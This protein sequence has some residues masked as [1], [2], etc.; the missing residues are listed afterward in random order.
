MYAAEDT[1]LY[2]T[3]E[4]S[5]TTP[6]CYESVRFVIFK[7]PV[8]VSERQV[9]LYN[10]KTIPLNG[11]MQTASFYYST[12]TNRTQCMKQ[13]DIVSCNLYFIVVLY[14]AFWQSV[15]YVVQQVGW[16]LLAAETANGG[17]HV[18]LA[19]VFGSWLY[20]YFCSLNIRRHHYVPPC[21]GITQ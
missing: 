7:N 13:I 9:R 19:Y 5:L 4:G 16:T 15:R 21:H 1:K 3:Y 2:W 6:P 8:E 14:V 12:V 20:R 10:N 18:K 11:W 17:L